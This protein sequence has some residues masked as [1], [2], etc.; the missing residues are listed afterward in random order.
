MIAFGHAMP[1]WQ[2]RTNLWRRIT[3]PAL[4]TGRLKK[5]MRSGSSVA[6]LMQHNRRAN[7]K[8]FII[9]ILALT[10]ASPA[11][12]QFQ[13]GPN[14]INGRPVTI[15]SNG[16]PLGDGPQTSCGYG[17]ALFSL[18]ETTASR[19]D[20]KNFANQEEARRAVI[21]AVSDEF[22]R[23][24]ATRDWLGFTWKQSLFT[25]GRMSASAFDADLA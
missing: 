3:N 23:R 18:I 7:M 17:Q 12:A 2:R 8:T 5:R 10:A 13:P 16:R 19:L 14:I 6:A 21:A 4:G 25:P 11:L 15:G 22:D 9:A 24:K 1:P 20:P